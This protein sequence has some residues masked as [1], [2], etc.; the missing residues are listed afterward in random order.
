LLSENL[1][2]LLVASEGSKK[3]KTTPP[4]KP[5]NHKDL[6]RALGFGCGNVRVVT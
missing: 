5:A 2:Q 6:L 3:K 1:K 4:K